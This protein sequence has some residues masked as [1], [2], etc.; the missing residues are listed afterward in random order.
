MAGL[1]RALCRLDEIADGA[2]RGFGPAPG[3][4]TAGVVLVPAEAGL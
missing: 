4:F 1:T 3:R 2:A